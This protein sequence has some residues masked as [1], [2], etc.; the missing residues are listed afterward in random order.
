MDLIG[1]QNGA[2]PPGG[3]LRPIA[4]MKPSS[5]SGVI[6][7]HANSLAK[8]RWQTPQPFN[9]PLLAKLISGTVYKE[10][11]PCFW[12][13][14]G[15]VLDSIEVERVDGRTSVYYQLA[16]TKGG[17]LVDACFVSCCS[18]LKGTGDFVV[19]EWTVEHPWAPPINRGIRRAS[20]AVGIFLRNLK[21]VGGK[22][23]GRGPSWGPSGGRGKERGG[24][25]TT[26]EFKGGGAKRQMEQEED[27]H[28][29]RDDDGGI[30]TGPA[31][32]LGPVT[33]GQG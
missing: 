6:G 22:A 16:K 14:G 1:L 8:F 19:A 11:V 17:E 32:P 24:G 2:A 29:V 30:A 25:G 28:E 13:L 26:G 12:A 31:F 23:G 27:R 4:G 3:S 18:P 10:K 9:P 7:Q 15:K 33:A 21:Q 5:S 20:G